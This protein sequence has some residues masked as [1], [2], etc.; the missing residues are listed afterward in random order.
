LA[1]PPDFAILVTGPRPAHDIALAQRSTDRQPDRHPD[2]ERRRGHN[3]LQLRDGPAAVRFWRVCRAPDLFHPRR[4]VY[5]HNV[6]RERPREQQRENGFH[7]IRKAALFFERG[8]AHL[9][10]VAGS[11]VDQQV[12]LDRAQIIENLSVIG[13]GARL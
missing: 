8:V 2:F 6:A 10:D 3:N 4:R 9:S 11:D 12:V 13:A 7:V 1:L 5:R